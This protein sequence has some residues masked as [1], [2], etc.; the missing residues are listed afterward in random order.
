MGLS[1]AVP[2]VGKMKVTVSPGSQ[3]VSQTV[4]QSVSQT[5]RQLVS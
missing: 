2:P 1:P 5:V 3:V 4:S